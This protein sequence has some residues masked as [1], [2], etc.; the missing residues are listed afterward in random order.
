MAFRSVP[1]TGA[2]DADAY[3]YSK[4]L[5]LYPLAEAGNPAPTKFVNVLGVPIHTLPFYDIRALQD[6]HDMISVEPVHV[7][8][9]Y[10][11]A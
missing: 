3:A 1:A 11:M 5:K 7:V 2:S 9:L 10:L 8:F 6:I 4:T